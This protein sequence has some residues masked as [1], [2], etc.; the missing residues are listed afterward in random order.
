MFKVVSVIIAV[1]ATLFAV[2]QVLVIDPFSEEILIAT[3]F[4]ICII[5]LARFYFWPKMYLMLQGADLDKNFQIVFPVKKVK[6]EDDLPT[7]ESITASTRAA[8]A[9]AGGSG[10]TG[11]G[12]GAGIPDKEVELLKKYMPKMP[13][14]M[15]D[16]RILMEHLAQHNMVYT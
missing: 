15:D 16:C 2:L 1:A 10:A 8:T 4:F 13:K 11:G 14:T 7:G 6:V 3:G 9:A 12:G 5:A